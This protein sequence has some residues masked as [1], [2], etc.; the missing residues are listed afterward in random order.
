ME[1]T[2]QP[3]QDGVMVTVVGDRCIGSIEPELATQAKRLAQA[4]NVDLL[5]VTF[6]SSDAGADFLGASLWLDL[7]S[8]AIADAILDHLHKRSLC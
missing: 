2:P 5:T 4:A 1:H 3:E 8:P 7:A 6:S